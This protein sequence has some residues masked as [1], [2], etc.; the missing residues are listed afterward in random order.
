MG[1]W[2]RG[3]RELKRKSIGLTAGFYA[4]LSAHVARFALIL[5]VLAHPNDPRVMVSGSTMEDAIELGEFFRAQIGR[6]VAMLEGGQATPAIST[7]HGSRIMRAIRLHEGSDP[8]S[9]VHRSVIY[10]TIRNIKKDELTRTPRPRGAR[11]D[12]ASRGQRRHG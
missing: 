2:Y 6:F 7:G 9:L 4:K 12:R 3:N 5:H 10:D 11:A 1:H 8:D